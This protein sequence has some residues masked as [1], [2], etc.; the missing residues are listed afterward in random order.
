MGS[1]KNEIWL[2]L[3]DEE[4]WAMLKRLEDSSNTAVD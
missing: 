1:E 3:P 4:S 2:H